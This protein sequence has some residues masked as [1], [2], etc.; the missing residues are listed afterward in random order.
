MKSLIDCTCDGTGIIKDG[1][2]RTANCP[3]HNVDEATEERIVEQAR[4]VSR[5]FERIFR[6]RE[7]NARR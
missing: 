7:L 4:R 1:S 2:W 3:V 5:L 6:E